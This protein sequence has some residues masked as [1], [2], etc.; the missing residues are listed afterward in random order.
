LRGVPQEKNQCVNLLKSRKKLER[1]RAT[2]KVRELVERDSSTPKLK[3]LESEQRTAELR[4]SKRNKR[5][6]KQRGM[7]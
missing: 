3:S 7:D 6:N 2:E 5:T 4:A 1:V